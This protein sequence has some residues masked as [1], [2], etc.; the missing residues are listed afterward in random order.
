[1]LLLLLLFMLPP[2]C[3]YNYVRDTNHVSRVYSV[4]SVLFLQF[5]LHVMLL[6]SSS[7]VLLH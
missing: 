6:H 1:M 3:S 4:A 7:F 2:L 5:V